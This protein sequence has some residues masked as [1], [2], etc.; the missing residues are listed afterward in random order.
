MATCQQC[1]RD[2]SCLHKHPISALELNLLIGFIVIV[3]QIGYTLYFNQLDSNDLYKISLI[4]T[5]SVLIIL[6]F[7]LLMYI[8]YDKQYLALF[9]GC[10]QIKERSFLKQGIPFI[11]CARCTGILIGIGLSIGVFLL[12]INAVL[13]V[14]LIMPL[15]LDGLIQR[16]SKYESRNL[17]RLFTGI[18]FAPGFLI[19]Y[20]YMNYYIHSFFS[21]V[22][23][24]VIQLFV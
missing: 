4:G 12:E 2:T 3:S 18:L 16:F 1:N 20:G 7:M 8:K 10:H 21:F 11:L 22:G 14:I 19:L 17:M 15:F 6:T 9:F 23:N 13:L 5:V 24:Q